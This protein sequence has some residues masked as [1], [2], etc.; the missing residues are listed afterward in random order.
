VLAIQIAKGEHV[1][2]VSSATLMYGIELALKQALKLSNA[3]TE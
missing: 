1:Y 2:K 3:E